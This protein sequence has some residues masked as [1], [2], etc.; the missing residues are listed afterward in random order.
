MSLMEESFEDESSCRRGEPGAP[1]ASVGMLLVAAAAW[2]CLGGLAATEVKAQDLPSADQLESDDSGGS[3]PFEETES[4]GDE[5]DDG[6]GDEEGSGEQGDGSAGENEGAEA[7]GE[8]ANEGESGGDGEEASGG[9]ASA[10]ES[11]GEADGEA[12]SDGEEPTAESEGEKAGEQAAETA[13]K[14]AEGE[15]G[16][17]DG[18]RGEVV[19]TETDTEKEVEGRGA[20]EGDVRWVQSGLNAYGVPGL[21]HIASASARMA[22]TYDVGFFGEVSGGSNI[23]RAQDTNTFV[24]GRLVVH[25]QPIEYFSANFAMSAQ[26]NVNEFGRP[27]AMLSQGDMALGLRGHYPATEYFDVGADVT[28]EVPTGFGSAGPSFEGTSVTPRLLGSFDL[29]PLIRDE[30]VPL[31]THLNVGYRVDNTSNTVPDG[32]ELTRVERF[33]HGIS[34]Y[35]ALELG[36]GVEYDVPYVSPFASW[37][38]D[39]PLAGPGDLCTGGSSVE[40]QCLQEAGFGAFPN[41]LS[42]GLRGE[43]VEQLALHAGADVSLTNQDAAGIPTTPPYKVFIGASWQ[44]DPRARVER[45]TKTVEKTR[46]VEKMPERGRI[47][48][49]ITDEESEMPVGGARIVYP[50]TD[51]SPQMAGSD[52]GTFRSYGFSPGETIAL[53]ISHPDYETREMEV[54]VEK[55]EKSLEVALAPTSRKVTYAGTVSGPDGQSIS[56]ATVVVDGPETREVTTDGTGQFSV[57]V[58]SGSYTVGISAPD[59]ESS[60]KTVDLESGEAPEANIRLEQ[61]GSSGLVEVTEE[62]FEIEERVAFASGT[63]QID[64]DSHEILEAVASKMKARPDVDRLEVQGHTDDVGSESANKELSQKRAE[65]VVEYLVEQGISEERLVPEGYGPEQ[66][67]VPNISDRNRRMNRRVE[68]KILEQ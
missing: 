1:R 49:E 37:N 19:E 56:G 40:L 59:Y 50:E 11:G 24:A 44:I 65:A 18:E 29:N 53:E 2:V 17:G 13:E 48:G 8:S 35:S 64:Q 7:A 3:S 26:N 38:L 21:Q 47:V 62:K 55:G 58:E 20:A 57:E 39:I 66:P 36:L 33:A 42:F 61:G 15:Q 22:N 32:I 52:G 30:E 25:A 27:E 6:G 12:E 9:E 4:G 46:M 43:P 5:Q 67:L 54:E 45:I 51:R 23:V 41:K 10:A 28:T 34:E 14:T 16:E 60:R 68:F 63:A 31:S